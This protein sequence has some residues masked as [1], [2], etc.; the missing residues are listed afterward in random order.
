MSDVASKV[1]A[2]IVD[3]LGVD[4]SEV[5]MEASFTND[6]GADSLD[7]VELIMEFEK[8]FDLAI[9]DDQA[10]KISTVGEAIKHIEANLK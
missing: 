10:E 2:I 1:K 3:K 6:L 9:P 8:E 7:T 4:E 5:T